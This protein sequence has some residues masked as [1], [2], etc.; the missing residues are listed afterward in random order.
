MKL[1]DKFQGSS[2]ER[3]EG[4]DR[5]KFK[6]YRQFP[7]K[8]SSCICNSLYSLIH[9]THY[10]NWYMQM[11]IQLAWFNCC[12]GCLV[13]SY[14]TITPFHSESLRYISHIHYN[15]W[16]SIPI[17]PIYTLIFPTALLI[18]HWPS[19]PLSQICRDWV[20]MNRTHNK[21]NISLGSCRCAFVTFSRLLGVW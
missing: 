5:P 1:I 4:R 8:R 20:R 21:W 9:W 11:F 3:F 12:L 10:I 6:N 17:K 15:S 14:S 19:Y 13:I 7:W 16:C 2:P 18:F